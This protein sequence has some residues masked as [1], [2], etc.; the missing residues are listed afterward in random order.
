MFVASV[1]VEA[2]LVPVGI[3]TSNA[4]WSVSEGLLHHFVDLGDLALS[5]AVVESTQRTHLEVHVPGSE[6]RVVPKFTVTYG[7][8]DTPPD[9]NP[10]SE[11]THVRDTLEKFFRFVKTSGGFECVP[12][13][14]PE[15]ESQ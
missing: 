3:I 6:Y 7:D 10:L 2:G 5:S 1:L 14:R 11:H 8:L 15:N 13:P 4:S 9:V 12:E